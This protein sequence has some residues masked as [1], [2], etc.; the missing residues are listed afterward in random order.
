MRTNGLV[1]MG[2]LM[3]AFLLSGCQGKTVA[4]KKS[5]GP[6]PVRIQEVKVRE[7]D[8]TLEY[9]GNIKAQDEALVYPKVSGKI[10]EKVKEDGAAVKKGDVIFYVDRD[11]VGLRFEKAPVESP[12]AGVVGRVYVDIGSNVTAQSAVA[13]VVNMDKMRIEVSLPEKYVGRVV[14]GQEAKIHV[15]AYPETVFSG[16]VAKI[17]PVLDTE[18]RSSMTEITV[19]NADHRLKS[20]MFARV[21]L[22]LE[23][24]QD[25]PV[26]PEEALIGKGEDRY[27]FIVENDKAALKKVAIDIQQG[28][29]IGIKEGVAAGDKVVVMGQQKL[30]DGADVRVGEDT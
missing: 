9:V 12:L 23:R 22:V 17:S 26:I 27:V 1:V 16:K 25:I 20:G 21:N 3:T 18:T 15:D 28:P 10:S 8:K 5:A 7:L 19:E 14:L 13:L 11:E 6:I 2:L 24:R 30:F 4:E 29:L